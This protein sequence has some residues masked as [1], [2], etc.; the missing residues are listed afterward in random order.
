[1][2]TAKGRFRKVHCYVLWL[3][4][5]TRATGHRAVRGRD[6]VGVQARPELPFRDNAV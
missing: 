1:M 5:A 2:D 4:G 3:R 6:A